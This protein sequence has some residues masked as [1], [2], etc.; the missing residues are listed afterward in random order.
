MLS[1]L[2]IGA[3]DPAASGRF[4]EAILLPLGY[5]RDESGESI[6]FSLPVVA[7]RDNGPGT[8]WIQRPFD[9]MPATPGNG[10]MPAFRTSGPEIVQ[11]LHAAGLAAGGSDEGGPGTRSY[12][13]EDFY[14]AYLRDPAG[15]KLA[16]FCV[17]TA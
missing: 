13:S 5:M 11:S 16:V 2:S 4:Y 12:Y 7:D 1:Y 10:M 15:N 6:R 8:I 9:R 3:N 17:L 14:V